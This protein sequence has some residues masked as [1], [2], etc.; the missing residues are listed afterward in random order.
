MKLE[1]NF[2]MKEVEILPNLELYS[3]R[4]GIVQQQAGLNWGFSNGHVS[5]ADAYIALTQRFFNTNPNFFPQQGSTILTEWDDGQIIYCSLEGTQDI[6]GVIYPKQISSVNDKSVLGNYLRQRI[7]VSSTQRI[8]MADLNS[9]GRID[10]SVS[11]RSGNHY[12]FDFHV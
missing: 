6:S 8:T 1:W 10:V 7:G 12:H 5:L 2:K 3:V 9:Y 11:H 4:D